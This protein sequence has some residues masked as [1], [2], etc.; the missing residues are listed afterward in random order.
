MYCSEYK[1]SRSYQTVTRAK[2]DIQTV[3]V[4]RIY[5]ILYTILRIITSYN[6]YAST[7]YKDTVLYTCFVCCSVVFIS[8]ISPASFVLRS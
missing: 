4:L 1:R 5:V 2:Q 6:R 8:F 7:L 3:R